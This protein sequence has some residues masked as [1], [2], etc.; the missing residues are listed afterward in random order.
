MNKN[1]KRNAVMKYLLPPLIILAAVGVVVL[2]IKT[3]PRPQRKPRVEQARLVETIDAQLTSTQLMIEASGTVVPARQVTL[4]PQVSGQV[5]SVSPEFEAGGIFH[6]DELMVSI[7]PADYEIQRIAR[8]ADV[9]RAQLAYKNELGMQ[10]IAEHEW[11]LID[12]SEDTTELEQELILRK[13]H[14]ESAEAALKSAEAALRKAELDLERTTIEA[15]F[16]LVMV[17]KQVD[18][19][20]LVSSQTPLAVVAGTDEYYINLT[21]PQDRLQWLN[22]PSDTN[23]SPAKA[24]VYSED[25]VWQGILIRVKPQLET[26]GRLAQ[27]LVSVPDPLRKPETPLML[28]SYVRVQLEGRIL[29][30]VFV[31]P[32]RLIRENSAVWVLGSD[33]R[34]AIKPVRV[35]WSDRNISVISQG[36][37]PGDKLITTDLAAPVEGMLLNPIEDQP[38]APDEKQGDA[39]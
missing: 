29:N 22:L 20:A 35:L 10:E 16:N 37:T 21:L 36:I 32:R 17:S 2:L 9:I 19:G 8:Q 7:D 3:R 13:P 24:S 11:E 34:L 23:A 12:S 4:H 31:L 5:L 15:P 39:A 26:Q 18:P 14:L 30:D 25:G 27:L 6:T 1:K 33:N 38:G 28:G